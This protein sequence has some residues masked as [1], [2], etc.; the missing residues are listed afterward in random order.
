[1][2]TLPQSVLVGV[3]AIDREHLELVALVD[4]LTFDISKPERADELSD[5]FGRLGQA[6]K[7]HFDNEEALI[8]SS[9]MPLDEMARHFLAH[10]EILEQHAD[11]NFSV[12][13][14]ELSFLDA[15]EALQN[16]VTRHIAEYDMTIRS[17]VPLGT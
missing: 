7:K 17:Y 9:G 5:G 4:R 6:L 10:E 15:S 11:F 14:G 8:E 12:M 16:W 2:P 3:P 13:N 1:M